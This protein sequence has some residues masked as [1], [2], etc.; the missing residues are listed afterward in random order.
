ML[1]RVARYS[2][3]FYAWKIRP[4][5]VLSYLPEDI[6]IEVTN[7]CNFKCHYCPQSN[8]HHFDEIERAGLSPERA[9]ILIQKIRRSGIKT[10]I[11]HWT[12]DGEPFVNRKFHQICAVAIRYGFLDHV[13]ASNGAL[14]S[15]DRLLELPTT[16]GCRY[17]LYVDFCADKEFFETWR[18][19]KGSWQAVKTNLEHIKDDPRLSHVSVGI[20]DILNYKVSDPTTLR[21]GHNQLLQMFKSPKIKIFTRTFHTMGGHLNDLNNEVSNAYNLCPYPWTSFVIAANGDV[22]ACG[23]DLGHKTILGN[24]FTEELREIWNG[25]RYQAFREHLIQERTDEAGACKH[26]DLPR[27]PTR[28]NM[29]YYVQ[30]AVHRLGILS[31]PAT[32]SRATRH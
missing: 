19:T 28:F 10:D 7:S 2:K 15:L 30:T 13:F 5:T 24:L 22:V 8:P 11:I 31:K 6:S 3:L 26:C 23:R 14:A 1:A 29:K 27:D 4:R 17:R 12:L 9:E 32:S 18:G 16:G 20:T 25:E 21:Q